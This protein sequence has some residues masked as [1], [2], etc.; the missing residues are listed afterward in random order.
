VLFAAI[1]VLVVTVGTLAAGSRL[2]TGNSNT[3]AWHT[4]KIA[5]MAASEGE[6]ER[7]SER[8]GSLQTERYRLAGPEIRFKPQAYSP[9]SNPLT[10]TGAFPQQVLRAPPRA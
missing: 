2:L 1:A 7:E 5:R 8:T 10:H 3:N 9:S 6:S 4:S